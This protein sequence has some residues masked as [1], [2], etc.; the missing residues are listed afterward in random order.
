MTKMCDNDLN[1][2]YIAEEKRLKEQAEKR[3]RMETHRISGRCQ[4]CGGEF[5]GLFVK[6]CT[7]CGKKR[8]Y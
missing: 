3:I 1:I 6:T 2:D 7:N 8:D 4:H 5:K